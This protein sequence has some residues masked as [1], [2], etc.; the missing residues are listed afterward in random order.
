M[1]STISDACVHSFIYVNNK[2]L[3]VSFYKTII[4]TL[5]ASDACVYGHIMTCQP[6]GLFV[7]FC[8]DINYD[9]NTICCLCMWSYHMHWLS[10]YVVFMNKHLTFHSDYYR[11]NFDWLCRLNIIDIMNKTLKLPKKL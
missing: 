5:T 7:T 11:F 1:T 6:L 4:M 9:I 10:D 3:F 2:G 8:Q